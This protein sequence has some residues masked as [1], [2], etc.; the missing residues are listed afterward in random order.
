MMKDAK[1]ISG[2]FDEELESEL[3]INGVSKVW[4]CGPPK[5]NESIVSSLRKHGHCEELYLLL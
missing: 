1:L 5:M 4:I 3:K 2:G